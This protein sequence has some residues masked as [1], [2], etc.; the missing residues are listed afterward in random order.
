MS[1]TK[2]P[3]ANLEA[4]RRNPYPGRGIIMGRTRED[5]LVQLYWIMGRSENSRNRVF[6]LRKGGQLRTDAADPE[7]VEDPS[8]IIYNAMREKKGQFVVSNGHQTDSVMDGL[9]AGQSMMLTLGKWA[10]EPDAPNYTPRITGLCSLH[11]PLFEF[12]VIRRI[13]EEGTLGRSCYGSSRQFFQYDEVPV[14]MGYCVTT[15]KGDGNPL[16]SFEGG[17]Y[18]VPV[19]GDAAALVNSYWDVLNEANR[20]SLAVKTIDRR[21]GRSQ[22]VVRNKFEKLKAAA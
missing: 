20:I 7:K 18:P 15:Y 9:L 14:G 3:Q 11:G 8:L 19:E 1:D 22:V 21:S 2:S 10:H 16:P 6:E 4:L 17:P 5:T 13:E 12:G